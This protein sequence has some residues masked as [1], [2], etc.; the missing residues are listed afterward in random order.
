LKAKSGVI[1]GLMRAEECEKQCERERSD[2]RRG[3]VDRRR[4]MR[5]E[6]CEKRCE[7]GRSDS[8]RSVVVRRRIG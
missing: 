5:A 2:D 1:E 3:L 6:E 7:W 4:F 8:R